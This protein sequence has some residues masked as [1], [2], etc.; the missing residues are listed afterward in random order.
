[1]GEFIIPIRVQEEKDL[2]AG[3]DPSGLSLS[4][5]LTDYLADYIEDRR[6]GERVCYE[7]R[8]SKPVDMER[9]RKAYLLHMEKLRRRNRHEILKSRVN[10]VRLFI[11]GI[12]FILIGL[13]F[14]RQMNDVLS[15]IIATV[16]SFSVWEASAVLIEVLPVLRKKDRI[17]TMLSESELK[18]VGLDNDAQIGE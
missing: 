9:L 6:L 16:G 12:A 18:L 2:Y 7:V 8:A 3:L 10:A 17:L 13:L 5:E 4:G 15:A 14:A 11:I 1:M